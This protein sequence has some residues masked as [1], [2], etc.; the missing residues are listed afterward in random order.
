MI[1]KMKK[2]RLLLENLEV[3]DDEASLDEGFK[4]F[5][6]EYLKNRPEPLSPLNEKDKEGLMK[7]IKSS[8]KDAAAEAKRDPNNPI[9]KVVKKSLRVAIY[10]G[11][12]AAGFGFMAMGSLIA[13]VLA[14]VTALCIRS[15]NKKKDN[16]SNDKAFYYYQD[17]IEWLNNKIDNEDDDKVK[18]NL[19]SLRSKYKANLGKLKDPNNKDD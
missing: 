11:I 14:T 15:S 7:I 5:L 13:P 16:L 19:F 8:L 9:N 18:K 10:A 3:I 1:L 12:G 4:I 2:E 17:T 6:K